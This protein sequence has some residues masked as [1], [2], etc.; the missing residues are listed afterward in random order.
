MLQLSTTPSVS[1]DFHEMHTS[2]MS[3][4]LHKEGFFRV[5]KSGEGPPPPRKIRSRQPKLMKPGRLI[6]YD[7]FYKIR[8]LEKPI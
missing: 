1:R 7:I 5:C 2:F 6:A 3:L 4:T 8:N